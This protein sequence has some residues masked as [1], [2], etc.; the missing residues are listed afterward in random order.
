[1]RK[2][3]L[4]I[5]LGVSLVGML[6]GLGWLAHAG[7]FRAN[8][9]RY[10]V[11]SHQ[12]ADAL[13]AYDRLTAET[14]ARRTLWLPVDYPRRIMEAAARYY[15]GIQRWH[16][17]LEHPD[18]RRLHE[19]A[20][21]RPP[22]AGPARRLRLALTVERDGASSATREAARHILDHEGFDL[23]ALW[24][25]A[26]GEYDPYHPQRVPPVLLRWAAQVD[27]LGE[28]DGMGDELLPAGAVDFLA[29]LLALHRTD[30]AG[31]AH[32]LLQYRRTSGAAQ[33]VA[34]ARALALLRSGRPETAIGPLHQALRRR[35][36]HPNAL[37][38][39]AEAHLVLG[40]FA[41]AGQTLARAKTHGLDLTDRV[42][43]AGLGMDS[44]TLGVVN[45]MGLERLAQLCFLAQLDRSSPVRAVAR[46]RIHV[47]ARQASPEALA[48]W[49]VR[50]V[51][52]LSTA[53]ERDGF[54][55]RSDLDSIA[56]RM[57][58][59]L[60]GAVRDYLL[61]AA[62]L[63]QRE[64]AL[65]LNGPQSGTLEAERAGEARLLVLLARLE[66]SGAV[67]PLLHVGV[68]GQPSRLLRT[69]LDSAT[70]RPIL[71]PLKAGPSGDPD[72]PIRVVV[73]LLSGRTPGTPDASVRIL[74][75]FLF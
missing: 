51:E 48:R 10:L 30:W 31:A 75:P 45:R 65:V 15:R 70:V 72:G 17:V 63:A 16:P 20:L 58:A 64:P 52:F 68:N 59:E 11:R 57:P 6:L 8:R 37:A 27:G 25:S 46:E 71:I 38:W 3:L 23:A 61:H 56:G 1:M 24:W 33:F 43:R 13:R 74:G 73:S 22:L 9:V 12:Y 69:K 18:Y 40:Q 42:L 34:P 44:G 53:G 29:G 28:A 47:L 5:L 60:G 35:P 39:L 62:H 7:F 36:R 26:A 32:R 50:L 19:Y 55:G 49:G 66:A 4:P 67:G 14:A 54:E 41:R 21:Q 2:R